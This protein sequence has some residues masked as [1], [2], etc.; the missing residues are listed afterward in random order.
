MKQ[1]VTLSLCCRKFYIGLV[2]A[3][4]SLGA[5]LFTGASIKATVIL[6]AANLFL[7]ALNVQCTPR[8]TKWLN[9]LWLAATPTAALILTQMLLNAGIA[10]LDPQRIILGTVCAGIILVLMLLLTM[11]IRTVVVTEMLL[12]MILACINHFV[13]TF[14]GSEFSPYDVLVIGTAAAVA[15]QYTFT[16][17]SVMVFSCVLAMLYCYAGFCIPAF[18]L[19]RSWKNAAVCAA[20]ELALILGFLWGSAP[21]QGLHFSQMGSVYNG[22]LLNFSLQIKNMYVPVPK[23]Y[24][25]DVLEQLDT[26]YASDQ[27]TPGAGSQPDIIVIMSESYADMRVFSGSLN[28]NRS[29]TPFFDSLKENTIRGYALASGIGGG[30]SKSEYEFLTGNS[31][32]WLP[33]GSFPFQQYVKADSTSIV[34]HLE[35]YGYVTMGTHPEN[36]KNYMRSSV[37]PALGFD[38]SLFIS[39]YPCENLLRGLVSD[40]EMYEQIIAWYEAKESEAPLFLFGVSMQNHGSYDYA[41]TDFTTTASLEGYSG[42]YPYAEQ[43]LTILNHSDQA[44]EYLIRYF[45]S[46]ENDVVIALFGDHFPNLDSGFY[47]ELHGGPFTSLEEQMLQ[48]TVPFFVWANFDIEEQDVGLTSLNFLSS[49]VYE[50]A[51]LPLPAYNAFLKDIQTVIPAMNAFGYYSNA[52]G[53]IIPY[54]DAEGEEAEALNLYRILQYNSLFD[55]DNRSQVFFPTE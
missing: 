37:Y 16:P 39:E 21:I 18:S 17:T 24:S 41:G 38:N 34:S 12:L 54:E 25:V 7:A 33:A 28:T 6:T 30:T 9:I 51:G 29:V 27:Q 53:T 43:Y 49:Y 48:Y 36:P 47:E 19:R 10:Y 1:R 15:E 8:I 23:Q 42:V 55:E 40:Q 20:L 3:V 2:L 44:L 13:Y 11:N 45:E 22:F 35:R 26:R 31:Q 50:A 46:V 4:L 5:C 14:R 52:N 32:A